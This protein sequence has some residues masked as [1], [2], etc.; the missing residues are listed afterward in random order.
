[1]NPDDP[2]N[3]QLAKGPGHSVTIIGAISNKN[4]EVLYYNFAHRTTADT[5]QKFTR[6][7]L[8]HMEDPDEAVMVWDNSK[9]HND[10]VKEDL[11]NA[12]VDIWPLSTYVSGCYCTDLA[13]L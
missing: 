6:S 3:F 12:G 1:M 10:Q 7:L 9:C 4:S 13:G 5:V 11:I 2:I 8:R